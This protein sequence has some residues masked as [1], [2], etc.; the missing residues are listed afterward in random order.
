[1]VRHE[2]LKVLLHGD[3][4][5]GL[6][7]GEWCFAGRI[8]LGVMPFINCLLLLLELYRGTWTLT[9]ST[10]TP[11]IWCTGPLKDKIA[12]RSQPDLVDTCC[13]LPM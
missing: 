7:I 1:M 13:R 8:V 2:K 9:L 5:Q 4:T 3:C 6:V 10:V 11:I 12:P